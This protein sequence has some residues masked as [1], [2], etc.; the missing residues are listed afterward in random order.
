MSTTELILSEEFTDSYMFSKP[1]TTMVKPSE[2]TVEAS[3]IYTFNEATNGIIRKSTNIE[4][5][6]SINYVFNEPS[7]I[8][9]S[10]DLNVAGALFKYLFTEPT[11]SRTPIMIGKISCVIENQEMVETA[12]V[13]K[14]TTTKSTESTTEFSSED[15]RYVSQEILID[16][17]PDGSGA[18][19]KNKSN[20]DG[21]AECQFDKVARTTL[22]DEKLMD[23]TYKESLSHSSKEVSDVESIDVKMKDEKIYACDQCSKTFPPKNFN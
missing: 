21:S 23:K 9:A 18:I 20:P 16:F 11:S 7:N 8:L 6:G 14:K 10:N 15:S 4:A 19:T 17:K 22:I 5:E 3:I 2:D 1:T 13:K 12:S